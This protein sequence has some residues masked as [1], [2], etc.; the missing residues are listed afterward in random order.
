M[1]FKKTDKRKIYNTTDGYFN[2]RLDIK[3]PRKVAVIH[4]RDDKAVAVVKI[5]S[6]KNKKGNAYISNLVLKPKKH[7]SLNEESIVSNS[8]I[9]GKDVKGKK[10]KIDPNDFTYTN[11]K[12]TYSEYL[13]I[14][15]KVNADT[16]Q[17]KKTRNK[18]LKRWKNHFKK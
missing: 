3:K 9:Y 4:Q 1:C 11:D 16:K 2:S 6:K 18:T 14:K 7:K 13:K 10:Y 15:H 5:H 17:H 12:L 8:L